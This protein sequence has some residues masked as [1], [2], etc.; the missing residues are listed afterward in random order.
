MPLFAYQ[1]HKKVYDAVDSWY[2]AMLNTIR[3][4][5]TQMKTF[6]NRG[7]NLDKRLNLYKTN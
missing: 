2:D 1:M 3:L 5:I 7:Y 4:E 6:T